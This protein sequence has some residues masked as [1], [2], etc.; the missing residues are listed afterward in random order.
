MSASKRE[1]I[2]SFTDERRFL[3]PNSKREEQLYGSCH[4]LQ[5]RC[6]LRTHTLSLVNVPFVVLCD[7]TRSAH[8]EK[9]DTHL[10]ISGDLSTSYTR[11]LQRVS[12]II[13]R[14]KPSKIN[15]ALRM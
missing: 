13:S 8:R 1:K 11:D 15:D 10:F 6:Q 3:K 4:K 5:I 9:N 12:I 7:G 14:D 2:E